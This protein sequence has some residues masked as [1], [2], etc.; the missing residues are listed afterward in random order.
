MQ[1][2]QTR[3]SSH[4][5]KSRW[6]LWLRLPERLLYLE[7][8]WRQPLHWILLLRLLI[9][10]KKAA[11]L[12]VILFLISDHTCTEIL[13]VG[14]GQEMV[15]VVPFAL[16]YSGNEL[17]NLSLLVFWPW[18]FSCKQ[19]DNLPVHANVGW[20]DLFPFLA[21]QSSLITC[22]LCLSVI[23]WEQERFTLF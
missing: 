12:R 4:L 18:L 2:L 21:L 23:P 7:A 16:L 10:D 9:R 15:P 22:F 5:H 1:Y 8:M 6:R 20:G 17:Y 3:R 13:L 11:C 14:G 19:W